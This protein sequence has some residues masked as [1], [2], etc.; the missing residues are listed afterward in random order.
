MR[1][2]QLAFFGRSWSCHGHTGTRS[3]TFTGS[4]RYQ[5]CFL[6]NL[7]R[8]LRLLVVEFELMSSL[9]NDDVK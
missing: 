1:H 4:G 5:N 6:W 9:M 8:T 7:S 2:E 3:G